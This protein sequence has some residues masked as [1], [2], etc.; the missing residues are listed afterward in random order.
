[1]TN[2][3]VTPPRRIAVLT[4]GGDSPGM[5]ACVRA[6]GRVTETAGAEL[7]AVMD[8]YAGLLDN[9]IFPSSAW[10]PRRA[11]RTAVHA[12]ARHAVRPS[13]SPRGAPAPRRT[14]ARRART[15][16]WSSVATAACAGR[17]PS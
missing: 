10:G 15:R 13:C 12:S 14:C 16:W 17:S 9:R 1:M 3:S 2:P 11:P 4:S 8:G 7:L 6:I 5:N